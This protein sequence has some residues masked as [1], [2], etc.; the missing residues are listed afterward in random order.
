MK[1]GTMSLRAT[2][3]SMPNLSATDDVSTVILSLENAVPEDGTD[4]LLSDEAVEYNGLANNLQHLIDRDGY[5]AFDSSLG[6]LEEISTEGDESAGAGGFSET[7]LALSE[8]DLPVAEIGEEPTELDILDPMPLQ[9]T[10]IEGDLSDVNLDDPV[11]MYLREIGR[12]PLLSGELEVELATAME[13]GRYLTE[14]RK[15][16]LEATGSEPSPTLICLTIYRTLRDG[17][18]AVQGIY[19]AMYDDGAACR[20]VLGALT[21][22]L[23]ITDYNNPNRL[24]AEQLK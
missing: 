21:P 2:N 18:P 13:L 3:G 11:R 6:A 17:W 10:A 20:E 19:D 24:S 4:D 14:T 12:V 1:Q 9:W 22:T 8:I 7:P 23:K 15:A 16:L 5:V